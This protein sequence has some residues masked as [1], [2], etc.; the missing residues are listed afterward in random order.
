MYIEGLDVLDNMILNVIKENARMSYSEIGEKVGVSRVS[1]KKR[2]EAMEEKGI[3]EGYKTVFKINKAP[4]GIS[5]IV[6][7]E[8][9]PEEFQNVWELHQMPVHWRVVSTTC[10]VTLK[11]LKN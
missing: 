3:I 4:E 1:V 10:S 6:D 2:M 5:F 7:V 8:A 9:F 11:E